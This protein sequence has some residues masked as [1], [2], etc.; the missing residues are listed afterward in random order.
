VLTKAQRRTLL[1]TEARMIIIISTI[2]KFEQAARHE[3]RVC[4]PS[5]LI[6]EECSASL[7]THAAF[8]THCQDKAL[9]ADLFRRRICED[10][11][12]SY[13]DKVYKSEHGRLLTANRMIYSALLWDLRQRKHQ[14]FLSKLWVRC[15]S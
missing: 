5:T 2:R 8:R 7:P 10:V 12:F 4:H 11:K 3:Y 13:V 15:Y 1:A 14:S 6:C 9:H